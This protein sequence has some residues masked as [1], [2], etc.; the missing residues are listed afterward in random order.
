MYQDAVVYK[1]KGSSHDAAIRLYA[2]LQKTGKIGDFDPQ[3]R[4]IFEKHANTRLTAIG[5]NNPALQVY[6]DKN[7]I[8]AAY[9]GRPVCFA[10]SMGKDLRFILVTPK[11]YKGEHFIPAEGGLISG[12]HRDIALSDMAQTISSIL[13][14]FYTHAKVP[15]DF[16][17]S[18]HTLRHA[19]DEYQFI[20]AWLHQGP[21]P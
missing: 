15:D 2:T 18:L 16:D 11:N 21:K 4:T 1:L 3:I 14:S 9:E 13:P 7:G 10:A 19:P 8:L 20:E 12:K 5:Q 17:E 6:K